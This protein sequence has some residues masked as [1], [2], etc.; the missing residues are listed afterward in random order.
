MKK[1]RKKEREPEEVEVHFAALFVF[2]GLQI[3]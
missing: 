1:E 3:H 2:W